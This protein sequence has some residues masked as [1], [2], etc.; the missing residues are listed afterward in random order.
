MTIIISQK[1]AMARGLKRYFTGKPCK[2]DHI[3]ERMVTSGHCMKCACEWVRKHHAANP[4]KVREKRRKY[5]A[6]NPEKVKEL[7]RAAARRYRAAN[8]EK[9][10]E[11]WRRWEARRASLAAEATM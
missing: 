9:V 8:P 1:E 3:A 6:A 4:E 11:R 10:R 2:H 5:R 7:N